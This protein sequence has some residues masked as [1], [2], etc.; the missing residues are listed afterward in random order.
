MFV[1]NLVENDAVF[2]SQAVH[3]HTVIHWSIIVVFK[4]LK[5]D[6]VDSMNNLR[7]QLALI[8]SSYNLI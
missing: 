3:I 8:M 1:V 2:F 4:F 5:K 7:W 6:L